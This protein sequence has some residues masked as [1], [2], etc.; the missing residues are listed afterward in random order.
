MLTTLYARLSVGLAI[1]LIAI[2]VLYVFISTTITRDYLQQ[3]NQQFNRNLA[4]DLGFQGT[5]EDDGFGN[6][7]LDGSLETRVEF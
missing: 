2:G 7:V 1:L 5:S 6:Q 3:V 4:R